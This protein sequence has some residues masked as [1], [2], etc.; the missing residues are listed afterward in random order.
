MDTARAIKD[1]AELALKA[2]EEGQLNTAMLCARRMQNLSSQLGV[3]N[4]D[5]LTTVCSRDMAGVSG[6]IHK[7]VGQMLT[8]PSTDT[9]SSR[10]LLSRE[11]GHV[12]VRAEVLIGHN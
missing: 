9:P 8:N 10:K 6:A 1:T 2:L 3:Q 4:A 5:R 11:V 7:Q 12:L